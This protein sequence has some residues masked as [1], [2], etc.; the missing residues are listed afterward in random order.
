[1]STPRCTICTRT[2]S[3]DKYC[4]YHEI[5][6]ERIRQQYMSWKRAYGDLS[7]ERY[8]ES[9]SKLDCTGVWALE[10]SSKELQ[11]ELN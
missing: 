10:V 2:C 8:L 1:M 4:K 9:I 5:A 7:W 11:L 6:F 3:S